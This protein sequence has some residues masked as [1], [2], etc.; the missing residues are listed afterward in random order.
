MA[1]RGG[2]GLLGIVGFVAILILLNVL[3]YFFNWGIW[4]Y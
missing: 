2:G 4:I 1:E 3:S